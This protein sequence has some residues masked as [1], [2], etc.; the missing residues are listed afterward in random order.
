M[1]A[2]EFAKE[3]YKI[4]EELGGETS[5]H[6]YRCLFESLVQWM[7]GAEL[8]EFVEHFRH[9]HGMDDEEEED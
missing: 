6:A 9:V 7:S 1:A 4:L 8:E 5:I 3:I 2:G